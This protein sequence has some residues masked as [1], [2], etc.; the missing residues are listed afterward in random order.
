MSLT[1]LPARVL[2]TELPAMPNLTEQEVRTRL[3]TALV[4]I[5]SRM[6]DRHTSPEPCFDMGSDHP[7]EDLDDLLFWESD[8][9]RHLTTAD[10][11]KITRRAKRY[12]KS[13]DALLNA[14]LGHLK[15]VER[16]P[17]LAAAAAGFRAT[18]VL[19]GHQADERSAELHAAFPWLAPASAAVMHHLRRISATAPR[20]A[21]VPPLLLVG[22]PGVAKSTWA[23]RLAELLA[24]TPIQIDIGATSGATFSI[25]GVERGW[26]SAAPG[27]VIGTMLRDRVANPVVILDEI[28][29]IPD[30]V[31][32]NRGSFPGAFEVLKSMIETATARAWVCP[33][34]QL[35]FDLT[36]VSWIMTTNS[37]TH[38]PAAFLDRVTVIEVGYPSAAQLMEVASQRLSTTLDPSEHDAAVAF[39]SEQLLQRSRAHRT[40]SL[41]TLGKL[42][43][44]VSA[45]LAAPGIMH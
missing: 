15:D 45:R 37:I 28:D 11:A 8:R 30:S 34:Y 21:H 41:R 42:I 3:T 35:P 4:T 33:Y 25:A 36:G 38:L 27:R 7:D 44:L 2:L 12:I 24:L 29:K 18:G 32:T 17:L 1:S 26:G 23:R 10:Q 14:S 5:R 19:T 13:R 6:S 31:G 9:A 22:P 40:T 16:K 43:D 20:P 39:I